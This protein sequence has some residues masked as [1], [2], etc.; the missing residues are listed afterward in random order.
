MLIV[1]IEVWSGNEL[2]FKSLLD[3]ATYKVANR[4]S[5]E[6]VCDFHNSISYCG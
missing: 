3:P 4:N 2:W 5:N 6:I 1:L